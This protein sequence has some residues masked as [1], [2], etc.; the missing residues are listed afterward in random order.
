MKTMA[1]DDRRREI[2]YPIHLDVTV[3]TQHAISA[4]AVATEISGDGIRINTAKAILPET[5]VVVFIPL[6]EEVKF[7]GKVLWILEKS[8]RG[9]TVYQIGIQTD[10]II[11]PD[12]EAVDF[13]DRVE[14]VQEI[15]HRIQTSAP[16]A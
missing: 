3:V 11:V 5:Q 16:R 6:T 7:R 1:D 13:S 15:L 14:L 12:R 10:S 8:E 9:L 2:R 4:S